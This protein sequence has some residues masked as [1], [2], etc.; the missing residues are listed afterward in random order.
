MYHVT[1][2]LTTAI[3]GFDGRTVRCPRRSPETLAEA[4]PALNERL[5]NAGYKAF[6]PDTL[7]AISQQWISLAKARRGF[8]NA[9]IGQ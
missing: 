3:N 4:I 9:N 8:S 1:T 5:V 6:L 7:R 2:V